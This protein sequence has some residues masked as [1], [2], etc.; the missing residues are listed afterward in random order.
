MADKRGKTSRKPCK[1]SKAGTKKLTAVLRKK[2][3]Q[4]I[5]ESIK[6]L[7][8][9]TWSKPLGLEENVTA[10]LMWAAVCGEEKIKAACKGL[11][12]RLLLL[13]EEEK[14]SDRLP[15]LLNKWVVLSGSVI[16]NGDHAITRSIRELCLNICSTDKFMAKAFSEKL[17]GCIVEGVKDVF[18]GFVYGEKVDQE[19]IEQDQSTGSED[20]EQSAGQEDLISVY[21]MGSAALFSIKKVAWK[22]IKFKPRKKE[23]NRLESLIQI[24]EAL[25][26]KDRSNIPSEMLLQNRNL[27]VMKRELVV[28]LEEFVKAFSQI[29]NCKGYK[30]Y[31]K[32]LFKVAEGQLLYNLEDKRKFFQCVVK[33]GV[34]EAK[35]VLC[36][37][38]KDFV[39]K[40]FNIKSRAFL[41]SLEIL[42]EEKQGKSLQ[43]D[44]MLRAKLKVSG[45]DKKKKTVSGDKK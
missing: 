1:L 19:K 34:K 30:T 13:F 3:E 41:K 44:T 42:E 35:P 32:K 20:R 14:G 5:F 29:V 38:F 4:E 26:E 9:T 23:L 28:P 17:T 10:K 33:A 27:L 8:E 40:L 21:R 16:N 43:R 22:K 12:N 24:V 15:K 7:V 39:R 45:L 11:F 25:E 2:M 31:G 6:G 18:W 37:F 36:K